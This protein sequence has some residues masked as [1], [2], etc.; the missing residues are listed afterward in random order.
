MKTKHRT[1]TWKL[2]LLVLAVLLPASMPVMTVNASAKPT[3]GTLTIHDYALEDMEEAGE[4]NDGSEITDLPANATPLAGVEFTVWEVD[5]AEAVNVTSASEAW[6]HVTETKQTGATKEDGTLTINLGSGLYYVAETG[7]TGAD[8]VVFSEPFL[9]SVPMEKPNGGGWIKDVHVYPKNQ[10]LFV[11]K[12]VGEPRDANYNFTDYEAAKY[13]PVA[14]DTAFGWSILSSLPANLGTADN[15]SYT[16]TEAL[17]KYFDY[18]LESVKVYTI[19]T[20]DTPVSKAYLLTEGSDYT[21]NFNTDTN[22]LTVELTDSGIILLGNRYKSDH[23]RYLLIKYDAKLN[24]TATHGVRLYSGSGVEVEYKRN[25]TDNVPAY[26][27]SDPETSVM[28]L[29]SS[30]GTK[31]TFRTTTITTTRAG[32]TSEASAKVAVEAAV[33]TGQIG[34]TKLEDGTDQLLEG[35]QFGLAATKADAEA[36]IFLAT[37]T[38]DENG[39][40]TFPGLTYGAP[41][42]S[43]TENN[44]NTTYWLVETKAP[45]GYQLV[46]DPVEVSFQYQQDQESGEYYFAKVDV[47]NVLDNT[48][49]GDDN[50]GTNKSNNQ[51]T[52]RSGSSVKTGDTSNWNLF[53]GSMLLALAIIVAVVVYRNKKIA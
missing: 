24:D 52:S 34:I 12:L 13:K 43:P 20:K 53:M 26:N 29:D 19:S 27:S 10:S 2:L 17:E 11:D 44:G 7:N 50:T 23:D 47:Y 28:N 39:E 18:V 9:V 25:V 14:M 22:T 38:T 42:D 33:H 48:S 37:G 51:L 3:S 31:V 16:V 32:T 46:K 8:K 36:G 15:E 1:Y 40:L 21:L 30:Y 35:A 45:E 41:G 5:P 49:A 6:Q 4:P